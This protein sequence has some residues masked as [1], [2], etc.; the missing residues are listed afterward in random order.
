MNSF[1]NNVGYMYV[2]EEIEGGRDSQDLSNIVA[3]HLREK[4]F[5]Y[6]KIILYSGIYDS[7]KRN[8]KMS[9]MFLKPSI[10]QA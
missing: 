9:I 7:Q 4:A 6:K 8:G 5:K 10:V 3:I 2:W 1:N